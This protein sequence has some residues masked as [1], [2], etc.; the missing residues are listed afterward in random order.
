M[1]AYDVSLSEL[2]CMRAWIRTCYNR[3]AA[4]SAQWQDMELVNSINIPLVFTT[5][6]SENGR[7]T[8]V[9]LRLAETFIRGCLRPTEAA[10]F[11]V[12][13]CSNNRQ[14]IVV[15]IHRFVRYDTHTLCT[16]LF[17]FQYIRNTSKTMCAPHIQLYMYTN[18][19][20]Y[21]YFLY[22]ETAIRMRVLHEDEICFTSM[23]VLFKRS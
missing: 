23:N 6:A 13:K 16:Q 21:L 17:Q 5:G 19:Q 8:Y 3:S 14:L 9:S 12:K 18:K 20:W 7:V 15:A 22:M 1:H 4:H 2:A 10:C 11:C